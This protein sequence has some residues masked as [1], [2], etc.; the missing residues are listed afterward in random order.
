M[1][2][3]REQLRASL[4][5]GSVSGCAPVAGL[6][7]VAG[8]VGLEVETWTELPQGS[9]LGGSSILGASILAALWSVVGRPASHD[10][11]IHAVCPSSISTR[12]NTIV[13]QNKLSTVYMYSYCALTVYE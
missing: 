2:P 8:D 12:I 6:G 10:D 1:A 13:I 11:I 9:G 3:L 7:A 5:A 4:A